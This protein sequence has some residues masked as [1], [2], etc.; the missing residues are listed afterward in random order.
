MSEYKVGD[1]VKITNTNLITTIKDIVNCGVYN[2]YR[3]DLDRGRELYYDRELELYI[4]EI[5][6]QPKEYYI[7]NLIN[8]FKEGTEFINSLGTKY[9]I[10]EGELYYYSIHENEW[11]AS[12]NSLKTILDMKFTKAEDPKLKQLKPMTFV[13]AVTTSKKIRYE[14]NL[15]GNEYIEQ[16]NF[17]TFNNTIKNMTEHYPSWRIYRIFL[18]GTWYAEGVYE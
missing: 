14:C 6:Q 18:K 2:V 11:V 13:E 5:K 17:E 8:D 12:L 16:N 7:Y 1:K 9:R 4:E 10:Q 3:V 15:K